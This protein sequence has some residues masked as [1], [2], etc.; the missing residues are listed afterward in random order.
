MRNKNYSKQ[1]MAQHKTHHNTPTPTCNQLLRRLNEHLHVVVPLA[2]L[3]L[4]RVDAG[5][6]GHQQLGADVAQSEREGDA[7]DRA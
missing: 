3:Q 1:N 2:R 7:A 6:L 5:D 4:D